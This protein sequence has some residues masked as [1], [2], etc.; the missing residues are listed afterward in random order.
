[1]KK[2]ITKICWKYIETSKNLM[3]IHL[4]SHQ[5]S[6]KE[7]LADFWNKKSPKGNVCKS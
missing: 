6:N 3:T 4:K 2:K 7:F 1:L 5:N